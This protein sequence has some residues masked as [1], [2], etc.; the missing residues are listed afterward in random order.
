MEQYKKVRKDEGK[1][2]GTINLES[3]LLKSL[4][5]KAQEWGKLADHPGKMVKFLK[6]PQHKTRFLSEE[7]EPR[8]LTV[9][10]PALRRVVQIGLLT[11]FRRQEMASLRPEDVDLERGTVSVAACYSK[12]GESRTLPVGPRLKEILQEVLAAQGDAPT[13]LLSDEPV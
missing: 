1:A 8:L 5:H 3:A 4:L 12:N 13:V 7:E 10:S 6:N 2:P 11:G 9:C